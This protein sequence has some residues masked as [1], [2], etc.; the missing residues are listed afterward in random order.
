MVLLG[1][2]F[3]EGGLGEVLCWVGQWSMCLSRGANLVFHTDINYLI[4]LINSV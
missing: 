1:V 3:G 2:G 4:I